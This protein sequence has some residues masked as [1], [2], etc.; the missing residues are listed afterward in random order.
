MRQTEV[1]RALGSEF[2]RLRAQL[3]RVRVTT[4]FGIRRPWRRICHPRATTRSG[5]CSGRHASLPSCLSSSPFAT[6]RSIF[7]CGVTNGAALSFVWWHLA[8]TILMCTT[9]AHARCT[10]TKGRPLG[11]GHDQLVA[12]FP[13]PW[14]GHAVIDERGHGAVVDP[15]R[16]P[17]TGGAGHEAPTCS[18]AARAASSIDFAESGVDIA[19][20][21]NTVVMTDD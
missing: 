10:M 20:V 8:A 3:D 15:L 13:H 5:M 4:V 11:R 17:G 14:P 12:S 19:A 1:T 6:S 7:R 18:D 21:S 9:S 2:I 16:A